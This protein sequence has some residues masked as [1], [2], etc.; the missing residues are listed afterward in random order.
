MS[1]LTGQCCVC[2]GEIVAQGVPGVSCDTLFGVCQRCSD[3]ELLEEGGT[4]YLLREELADGLFPVGTIRVTA[5]AIQAL[6]RSS[7]Q[8]WDF[9]ARHVQGD[10]GELGR[11]EETV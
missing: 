9:L 2:G 6:E 4:I 10:W 7:Q 1:V 8:T 11:L 5:R 3:S